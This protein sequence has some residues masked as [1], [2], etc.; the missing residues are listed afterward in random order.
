MSRKGTLRRREKTNGLTKKHL[1]SVKKKLEAVEKELESAE[2]LI[3]TLL[4]Q[5]NTKPDT[6]KANGLHFEDYVLKCIYQLMGECEVPANRCKEVI[7]C[8]SSNFFNVK[9]SDADLP[10]KTSCLRYAAHSNVLAKMQAAEALTENK[11]DLHCDGTTKNGK[12]YVAMQ[13]NLQNKKILSLGFDYVAQENAETLLTLTLDKVQQLAELGDLPDCG[14]AQKRILTNLISTM[15]DRAAVMKSYS[16]LLNDHRIESL[17]TDV[18]LNYLH[19]NAHFL[20][21]LSTAAEKGVAE[22]EKDKDLHGKLGRDVLPV[23]THFNSRS[24]AASSR[25]ILLQQVL[26]TINIFRLLKY[27]YHSILL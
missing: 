12:K 10:G 21:A 11:F 14:E 18:Q 25:Y 13:A 20:L 22:A 19:C 6:K 4:T 3:M 9:F 2:S 27:S 26:A 15:T 24:Q 8:V 17:N 7:Q 23:F 5:P 1:A 16:R